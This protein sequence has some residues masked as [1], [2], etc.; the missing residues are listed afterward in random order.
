MG[1]TGAV[2]AGPAGQE[3]LYMGIALLMH[4]Q[5]Q[6][7]NARGACAQAARRGDEA[8]AAVC[9][10]EAERA[11]KARDAAILALGSVTGVTGVS[12]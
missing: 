12:A 4:W 11:E 7:T 10:A 2:V 1:F 8:L 3:V 5:R 6:L 9:A